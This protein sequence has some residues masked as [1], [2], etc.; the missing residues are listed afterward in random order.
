MSTASE[1]REEMYQK[2]IRWVED[3]IAYAQS[4]LNDQYESSLYCSAI[5]KQ[6]KVPKVNPYPNAIVAEIGEQFTVILSR[7]KDGIER[8]DSFMSAFKKEIVHAYAKH[9]FK[10]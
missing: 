7:D 2:S 5:E 9:C 4:L 6:G 1:R 3:A 10:L 8:V